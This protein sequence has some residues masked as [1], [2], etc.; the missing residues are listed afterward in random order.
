MRAAAAVVEEGT[1]QDGKDVAAIH[2]DAW[3]GRF[4]V[5]RAA[6]RPLGHII[7]IATSWVMVMVMVKMKI[8]WME[9]VSD[10]WRVARHFRRVLLRQTFAT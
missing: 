3:D 2:N 9:S 6:A 4:I 1:D 5:Y 8:E 7:F 10:E